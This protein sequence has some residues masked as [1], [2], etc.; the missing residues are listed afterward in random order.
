[1]SDAA[2]QQIASQRS[3]LESLAGGIDRAWSEAWPKIVPERVCAAPTP[4]G[5]GLRVENSCTCGEVPVCRA[6]LDGDR[7]HVHVRLDA[8]SPKR[9]FDCYPSYSTCSLPKLSANQRI[10][11]DLDGKPH[12]ELVADDSGWL[13][14]GVCISPK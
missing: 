6:E 4:D 2:G 12:G 8:T 7:V 11:L 14:A 1:M 10:R 13:P 9:C 5:H 3:L